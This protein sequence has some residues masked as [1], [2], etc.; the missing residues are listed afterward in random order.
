MTRRPVR[1]QIKKAKITH[2]SGDE[3]DGWK[4]R[5]DCSVRRRVNKKVNP[6]QHNRTGDKGQHNTVSTPDALGG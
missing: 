4:R 6:D 2:L 1:K 3:R 5:R